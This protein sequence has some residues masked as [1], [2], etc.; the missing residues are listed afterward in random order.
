V[1]AERIQPPNR[2]CA[3]QPY[4]GDPRLLIIHNR[5]EGSLMFDGGETPPT[6]TRTRLSPRSEDRA[7][8]LSRSLLLP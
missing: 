1:R 5:D 8:R 7:Q 4:R 6:H 3:L 2:H